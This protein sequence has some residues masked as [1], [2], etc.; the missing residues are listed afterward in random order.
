MCVNGAAAH[1]ASK[2]DLIIIAT[3]GLFNEEEVSHHHPNLIYVDEENRIIKVKS[4]D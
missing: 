1:Q 2:D 3:F 4:G